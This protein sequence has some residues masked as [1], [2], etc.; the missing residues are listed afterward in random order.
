MTFTTDNPTEALLLDRA[1]A[2]IRELLKTADGAPDGTVL[3]RIEAYLLNDGRE[4]LRQAAETA[5]QAQA[6]AVEKKGCRSDRVP[7]DTAA[8]AK[9]GR[10]GNC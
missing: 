2:M 9:A 3:R 6:A 1:Q 7:A 8:T 10:P 5:A 4:F